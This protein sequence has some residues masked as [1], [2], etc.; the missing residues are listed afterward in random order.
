MTSTSAR[1][2]KSLH[3]S[4]V[5]RGY[6]NR[7]SGFVSFLAVG[8]AIAT[9]ACLLALLGM[10][11]AFD[12]DDTF[13]FGVSLGIWVLFNAWAIRGLNQFLQSRARMERPQVRFK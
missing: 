12:L 9:C 10:V 4:A 3:D 1:P 13:A 2:T 5:L 7:H 8:F 11:S 6:V